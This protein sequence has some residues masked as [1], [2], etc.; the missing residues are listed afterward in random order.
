MRIAQVAPLWETVPPTG[1][2]GIELVV[3]LL[4]D[5]LVKR[6]HEVTLFAS[7]DSRTLAKLESVYPRAIRTDETVRD[8]NIYLNLELQEVYRRADEFDIIH[9]HVDYP[10]L[11]YAN[12]TKTPTVHTLHGPLSAE[13]RFLFTQCKHQNYVS[14]SHSQREPLTDLNY[15]GNVYNGIDLNQYE[16][17]NYPDKEPYL[18]FLGRVSPEK[19]AHRAIEIA[20]RTGYKLKM[21][22]KVDEVDRE[23]FE[24]EILAHVDGKQIELMGEINP[25]EK[26][27]LIGGAIATLF[28]INWREPF[29]LVMAESMATGTPVIAM[30]MGAAPEVIA[31]GKTGFLCQTIDEM[32]RAVD[33]V[34]QINRLACR[35]HVVQKFGATRMADGYEEVYARLIE[36][37][38]ASSNGRPKEVVLPKVV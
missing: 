37:R 23:F 1:Y 34:G 19:G 17:H 13:N 25:V 10:A 18:A 16:F 20:K 29:G 24:R 26:S 14:I 21:A 28:P 35:D 11:P 2:G 3:A 5:E 36:Q 4:T 38:F 6:G 32:V 8:Y 15:V 33:K 12:F 27:K 22:C 30:A 7:G 9:S 31:H